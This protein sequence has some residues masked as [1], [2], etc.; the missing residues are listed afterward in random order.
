MSKVYVSIAW[1]NLQVIFLKGYFLVW[2]VKSF[3]H[4][5]DMIADRDSLPVIILLK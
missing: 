2:R 4:V 5:S 1:I 3:M